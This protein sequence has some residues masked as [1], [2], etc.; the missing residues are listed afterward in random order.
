ME[1]IDLKFERDT[2]CHT[3]VAHIILDEVRIFV[4]AIN[5]NAITRLPDVFEAWVE[6]MK[7]MTRRMS[8]DCGYRV[9]CFEEI[10]PHE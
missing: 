3:V 9:V 2:E 6:L 5:G 8:Q 7:T 1:S 10:K 4:G